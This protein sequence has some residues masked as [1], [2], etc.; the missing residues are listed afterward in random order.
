MERAFSDLYSYYASG[1]WYGMNT[2]VKLM[3]FG[4]GEKTYMAWDGI[5]STT[6]G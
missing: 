6:L 5:D 4:G 3:A 2:M 1:A